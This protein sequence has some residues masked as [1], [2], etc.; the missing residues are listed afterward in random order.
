MPC[1]FS[2][3]RLDVCCR[4][5]LGALLGVVAH[6]CALSQRL[7][8]VALDRAVVNEQVLAGVIRCDESE[9]LVVAEPLHCSCSHL[10]P[11]VWVHC[12][13]GGCPE[14]TTAKTRAP[15]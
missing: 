9:A 7:E 11:S 5:A 10:G 13:R 8:A 4:R 12:E 14:A 15:L 3:K 1:L 6:L 2:L